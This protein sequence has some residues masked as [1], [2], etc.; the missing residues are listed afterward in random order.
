MVSYEWIKLSWNKNYAS[1]YI[2][3][4]PHLDNPNML[5]LLG[6]PGY[7]TDDFF[8]TAL[9]KYGEIVEAKSQPKPSA[10]P[11]FHIPNSSKFFRDFSKSSAFRCV[12]VQFLSPDG[13]SHFLAAAKMVCNVFSIVLWYHSLYMSTICSSPL[14]GIETKFCGYTQLS[15]R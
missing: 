4:C 10:I 13:L 1:H 8:L 2:P 11:K 15:K 14:L 9:S 12:F 7:A 6:V 3:C 5:L